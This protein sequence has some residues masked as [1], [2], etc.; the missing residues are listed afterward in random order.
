MWLIS[1]ITKN[2]PYFTDKSI[3]IISYTY[4][5]YIAS[6]NSNYKR[7]L[8]DLKLE[9]FIKPPDC[10]NKNSPFKNGPSGQVITEDVNIIENQSLRKVLSKG[11]KYLEPSSINWSFNFEILNARKRIKR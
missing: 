9:D 8:Q 7:L 10:S 2:Y 5:S 6:K 11:P 1:S 3:P 4:T